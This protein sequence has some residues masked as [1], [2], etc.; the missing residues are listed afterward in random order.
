[1]EMN[2]RRE[3]RMANAEGIEKL[4]SDAARSE[5]SPRVET[6]V[7]TSRAAPLWVP[8]SCPGVWLNCAAAALPG[9][10]HA[11]RTS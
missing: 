2:S 1:M 7:A 11:L 6:T 5:T 3:D 9:S 8:Q 4:T 10:S